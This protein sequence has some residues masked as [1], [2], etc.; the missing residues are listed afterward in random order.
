V[1]PREMNVIEIAAPG[2]PEHLRLAMRP[3]P[4]PG[5]G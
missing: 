5:A 2:G 3:V 4:K 1:I